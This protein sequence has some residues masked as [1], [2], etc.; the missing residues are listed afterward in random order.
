MPTSDDEWDD[1]DMDESPQGSGAGALAGIIVFAT[2]L[3][4][5]YVGA[6]TP[7][8]ISVMCLTMLA[9]WSSG[10]SGSAGDRDG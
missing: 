9:L 8:S 6:Y 4:F 7:A 5:L 2:L 3:Y 10:V 1:P